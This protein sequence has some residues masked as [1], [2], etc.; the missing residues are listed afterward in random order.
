M[1]KHQFKAGEYARLFQK[2]TELFVIV[3]AVKAGNALVN[4]IEDEDGE[5]FEVKT[6]Q[7]EYLPP[8]RLTKEDLRS[9]ARF[10]LSEK[11]LLHKALPMY[12]FICNDQYT[13]TLDDL[14]HALTRISLDPDEQITC[15]EDWC[16]PLLWN[17]DDYIL[18]HSDEQMDSRSWFEKLKPSDDNEMAALVID[19]LRIENDSNHKRKLDVQ[20]VLKDI[21]AFRAGKKIHPWHW[22]FAAERNII[23]HLDDKETENPD[24]SIIQDFRR[25]TL[26]LAKENDPEALD[27]LGYC[28]YGGNA[29]FPCD[30]SASRDCFLKLLEL[31]T[32]DEKR[33]FFYANTLGYIF[34]YGRDNNGIPEYDKA[35]KYFMLGA[36][37]GVFESIYKLSDMYLH[38]YGTPVNKT[39]AV[40]MIDFIWDQNLHEIENE[41]FDCKFADLALRKGNFCRDGVLQDDAYIFYTLADFAI[42]KRLRFSN[43]GDQVVFTGIQKELAKIRKERPLVKDRKLI[44]LFP[45]ALEMALRNHAC[46]I[47]CK[48]TKT[49]I[50]INAQRL[51]NPDEDRIRKFLICEAD[52]QY[53]ELIDH[54]KVKALNVKESQF[55]AGDEFVAD[56]L[57]YPESGKDTVVQFLHHGVV[58]ASVT[59]S[60]FE[61]RLP[62]LTKTEDQVLHF[63]SVR[64]T[65]EG[66]TYDY[67]IGNL[68][69][70]PEDHVIV[71]ANGEE[72]EVVVA[73]VFDMQINDLPL[74]FSK[75]KTILKKL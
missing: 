30:W 49:G 63:A 26:R 55:P 67:L 54:V 51:K 70:R 11:E 2:E 3:R 12:N 65:P 31:D 21:D 13:I 73:D 57:S 44:T 22:S 40:N 47:S 38:G 71:R 39:A 64:F 50:T 58:V 46:L 28:Y 8:I 37:G 41:N 61:L 29:F 36:A 42:R 62:P 6:E 7:M 32:V 25:I 1:N 27:R 34:Y 14:I 19:W 43:Y 53:C 23:F 10:E 24:P 69:L 9:F 4:L 20:P 74:D 17:F 5:P 15:F 59:A 66:R 33:K 52:H 18:P 72:K 45:N 35:L 60:G 16:A 48:E 75:Y 56:E 68:K